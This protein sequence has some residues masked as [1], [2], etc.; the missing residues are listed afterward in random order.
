MLHEYMRRLVVNKPDD[1]VKFLIKSITENPFKV[2]VPEPA[3]AAEVA[4]GSAAAYSA[5]NEPSA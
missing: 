1:P 3:V 5:M 2:T 4:G